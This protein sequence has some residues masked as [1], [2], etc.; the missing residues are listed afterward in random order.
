MHMHTR[1]WQANMQSRKSSPRHNPKTR[2]IRVYSSKLVAA[3]RAR[4]VNMRKDACC[5]RSSHCGR[6]NGG[7][8]ALSLLAVPLAR[9]FVRINMAALGSVGRLSTL[10]DIVAV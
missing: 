8:G 1:A 5:L 2:V 3:S 6:H 7:R 4:N 9:L 10:R